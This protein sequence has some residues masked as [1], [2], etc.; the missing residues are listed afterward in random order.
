MKCTH[1]YRYMCSFV[2]LFN[3]HK[4]CKG[5]GKFSSCIPFFQINKVYDEIKGHSEWTDWDEDFQHTQ[6]EIY[7]Y[8]I[9]RGYISEL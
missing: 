8:L 9:I 3:L 6:Q 2:I 5:S 1:V 7:P 4:S